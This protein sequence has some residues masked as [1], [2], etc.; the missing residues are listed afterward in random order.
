MVTTITF[1]ELFRQLEYGHIIK[2]FGKTTV[3][4]CHREL[5]LEY[6]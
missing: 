1:L 2:T 5:N 6:Q 4:I 3:Q